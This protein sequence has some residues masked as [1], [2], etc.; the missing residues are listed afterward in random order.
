MLRR[1]RMTCLYLPD[2]KKA[3]MFGV[4]A[5]PV[6]YILLMDAAHPSVSVTLTA[7]YFSRCTS[8]KCLSNDSLHSAVTCY[9]TI[10][11]W[12]QNI[13]QTELFYRPG[14]RWVN[15]PDLRTGHCPPLWHSFRHSFVNRETVRACEREIL[16][17]VPY[18]LHIIIGFLKVRRIVRGLSRSFVWCA[19]S[20]ILGDSSRAH[21]RLPRRP[22]RFSAH[23][24]GNDAYD[25]TGFAIVSGMIEIV[26]IKWFRSGWASQ[27]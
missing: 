9:V 5:S 13:W 6:W 26:N 25:R 14:M 23:F 17:Y 3:V 11:R 22:A 24:D 20:W 8:R 21:H 16:A 15:T 27:W 19:T 12:C 18:N 10:T 7:N 1:M 4:G 2:R